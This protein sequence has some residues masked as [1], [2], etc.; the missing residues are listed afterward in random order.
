MSAARWYQ[1]HVF[2]LIR[3]RIGS[4]SYA[5]ITNPQI[6]TS[7]AVFH[8]P[9]T[10]LCCDLLPRTGMDMGAADGGM[11]GMTPPPSGMP[12]SCMDMIQMSFVWSTRAQILFSCWP[13]DRGAG[14]YLLALFL[15]AAASGL[16]DCLSVAIRSLPRGNRV[17]LA[18]LRTALH[19]AR[20]GLAY[21]VMLAVMSFNVGVLIAAIVGHALGFFLTGSGLLKW[22]GPSSNGLIMK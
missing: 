4:S 5:G 12:T 9:Y 1:G 15:V 14:A 20:M 7:K 3:R 17:A 11:S 6:S 2:I 16:V 21:L 13:G 22:A 19:A 10:L 8:R 18:L